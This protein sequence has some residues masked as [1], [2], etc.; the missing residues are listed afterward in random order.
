[1]GRE[2]RKWWGTTSRRCNFSEDCEFFEKLEGAWQSRGPRRCHAAEGAPRA[3]CSSSSG[4]TSGF[5]RTTSS[6]RLAVLVSCFGLA[7]MGVLGRGPTPEYAGR[8]AEYLHAVHFASQ[9]LAR[10]FHHVWAATG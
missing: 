6:G 8:P 4:W 9:E 1:M 10:R 3:R 7:E 5:L 2:R